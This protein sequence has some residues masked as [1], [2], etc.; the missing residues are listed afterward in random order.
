MAV[1]RSGQQQYADEIKEILRRQDAAGKALADRVRRCEQTS[2]DLKA[3]LLHVGSQVDANR[4]GL[5][6]L[7]QVSGGVVGHVNGMAATT[8]QNLAR[9]KKRIDD[10][11][12]QNYIMLAAL[13][14]VSIG[15]I[16]YTQMKTANVPANIQRVAK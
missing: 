3:A 9:L 14:V 8:N 2:E 10:L 15:S 4:A 1:G 5:D 7:S 11:Q 13:F 12:V 6:Q 16:A